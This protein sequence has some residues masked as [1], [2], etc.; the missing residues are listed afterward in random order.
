MSLSLPFHTRLPQGQVV[1]IIR[2]DCT[3]N[4]IVES[5]VVL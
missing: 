3:L 1:E 2:T 4:V 5:G